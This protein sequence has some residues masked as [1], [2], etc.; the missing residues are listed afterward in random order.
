MDASGDADDL[1]SPGYEASLADD[2]EDETPAFHSDV[3]AVPFRAIDL[4]STERVFRRLP[5]DEPERVVEPFDCQVEEVDAVKHE[6]T[7]EASE[8]DWEHVGLEPTEIELREN[9]WTPDV[10][11]NDE[12]ECR[13]EESIQLVE[14]PEPGVVNLV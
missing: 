3:Y 5:V 10:S 14:S 1:E 8:E 4:V 7:A 13:T 11:Q 2:I 6:G 9:A 12:F